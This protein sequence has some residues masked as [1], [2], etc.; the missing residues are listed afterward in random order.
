MDLKSQEDCQVHKDQRRNL[1]RRELPHLYNLQEEPIPSKRGSPL[2]TRI[3]SK[4]YLLHL[5]HPI[6]ALMIT[7]KIHQALLTSPM[8]LTLVLTRIYQVTL[9]RKLLLLL[10]DVSL[11]IYHLITYSVPSFGSVDL[12]LGAPG[13][14]DPD[15][16]TKPTSDAASNAI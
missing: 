14:C 7:F 8:L 9:L 2:S 12:G 6:E 1:S 4:M 11:S 10:L 16:S 3:V 13:P 15:T 5:K